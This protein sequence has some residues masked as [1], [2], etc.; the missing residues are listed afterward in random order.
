MTDSTPAPTAPSFYKITL[1]PSA[2]PRNLPPVIVGDRWRKAVKLP[3]GTTVCVDADFWSA[4]KAHWN[5]ASFIE[6]YVFVEE[7]T[8]ESAAWNGDRMPRFLESTGEGGPAWVRACRAP[9]ILRFWLEK[10]K[11]RDVRRAIEAQIKYVAAGYA[12]PTLYDRGGPIEE[13]VPHV[14]GRVEHGPATGPDPVLGGARHVEDLERD[15][16]LSEGAVFLCAPRTK[17]DDGSKG[18]KLGFAFSG[19]I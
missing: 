2:N 16:G 4:V 18:A 19:V 9:S 5:F 10:S 15:H 17:S 13:Q 11:D 7:G 12:P 14:F 1:K 8:D 6:P 3:V